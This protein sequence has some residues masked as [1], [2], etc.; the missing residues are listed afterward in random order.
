MLG[1]HT[2]IWKG[3]VRMNDPE[4]EEKDIVEVIRGQ[5]KAKLAILKELLVRDMDWF[6]ISDVIREKYY[7]ENFKVLPF[8]DMLEM[9]DIITK[10]Q[11]KY[12][13][14]NRATCS[15]IFSAHRKEIDRILSLDFG[16]GDFA[17]QLTEQ[18]RYILRKVL[19]FGNSVV[20]SLLYDGISKEVDRGIGPFHG[21]ASSSYGKRRAREITM[22]LVKRGFLKLDES[23]A[24]PDRVLS[25]FIVVYSNELV[26]GLREANEKIE[27]L[28]KEKGELSSSIELLKT[29]IQKWDPT[30]TL[31][32]FK[33][34]KSFRR[35]IDKAIDRIDERSFSEAVI[36]CYLVSETL[37]TA[38]FNFLYPDS[39]DKRIKHEDKL[40]RIWN[41]E[42][43]EKHDL[44]GIKVIASLLSA[45]LWYRNKMAA[46]TEMTPTKEAARTSITSLIQ[47]LSE[48]ERLGI[49][50][51]TE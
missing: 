14:A 9:Q 3:K 10:K 1:C 48:F 51:G 30:S 37:I 43:K 27:N 28:A 44:P 7:D 26:S 32:A 17:Y 38:L 49:K 2:R 15:K 36:N 46:H 11:D 18:E 5:E 19:S 35:R 25:D 12:Q 42:E 45:I 39:K 47:A 24:I 13:I 50:I 31:Q 16:K 29:K 21:Y 40:K 20:P 34:P 22:H 8:I 41:D 4:P 33:I 6:G 23:V